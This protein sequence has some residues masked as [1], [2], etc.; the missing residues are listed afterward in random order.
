ML[1]L[2]AIARHWILRTNC[3]QE[4]SWL[5]H[6]RVHLHLLHRYCLKLRL[7]VLRLHLELL[8]KLRLL[9]ESDHARLI[10][11]VAITSLPA[12]L[13]CCLPVQTLPSLLLLSSIVCESHRRCCQGHSHLVLYEF[14]LLLG[15]SL[16]MN[17]FVNELH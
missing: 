14:L 3:R 16:V 4:A 9:N 8:S 13:C 12:S 5:H 7:V 6:L 11:H 1:L 10:L 2:V 17:S 15:V